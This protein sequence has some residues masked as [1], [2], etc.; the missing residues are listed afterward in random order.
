MM[1]KQDDFKD[2][3]QFKIRC[4]TF[5]CLRC[6][7]VRVYLGCAGSAWLTEGAETRREE[8]LQTASRGIKVCW[9]VK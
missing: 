4:T 1:Q 5:S 6:L 3:S 7:M 9:E 2:N 8:L